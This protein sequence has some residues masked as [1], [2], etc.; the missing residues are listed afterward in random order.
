MPSLF[1][2]SSQQMTFF[3]RL[4]NTLVFNW[5]AWQVNYYAEI[6][7]EHVQKYFDI[8]LSSIQELYDDLSIVLVNSHYSLN[9]ITPAVPS[10]IN[11]GGIH[12]NSNQELPAVRFNRG[13]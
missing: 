6:Q 9:E 1:S 3:E 11:I 7:R 10:F 2:S 5:V 4:E 8:K 13:F 12:V